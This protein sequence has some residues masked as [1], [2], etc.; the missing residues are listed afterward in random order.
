[1]SKRKSKTLSCYTIAYIDRL[2]FYTEN[3]IDRDFVIWHKYCNAPEDERLT[4]YEIAEMVG[5]SQSVVNHTLLMLR[6]LGE[7]Q[8]IMEYFFLGFEL[9]DIFSENGYDPNR[10]VTNVLN[11]LLRNGIK[12]RRQVLDMSH[13]KLEQFLQ[14]RTMKRAGNIACDI[15]REYCVKKQ[16]NYIS[17]LTN[18]RIKNAY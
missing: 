3:R 6:G 7:W 5:C 11:S 8:D 13:E 18:R 15:F 10:Y 16:L 4:Q 9:C 14:S 2:L 1:M 17:K 12:T